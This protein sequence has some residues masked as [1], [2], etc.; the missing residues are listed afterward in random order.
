MSSLS[1]ADGEITTSP[2]AILLMHCSES[3]LIVGAGLAGLS[4][5]RSN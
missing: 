3:L 1:A 2:A 5:Y 4:S